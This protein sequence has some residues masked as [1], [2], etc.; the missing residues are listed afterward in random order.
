MA[1]SLTVQ[2]LLLI[3]TV[4]TVV[5]DKLKKEVSEA[6][7]QITT[8]KVIGRLMDELVQ[9]PTKLAT[10]V[11]KELE[12][13]ERENKPIKALKRRTVNGL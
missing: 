6:T 2:R 11:K 5:K 3:Q 13:T 4:R 7:I 12:R 10:L 9:K 1:V 8:D